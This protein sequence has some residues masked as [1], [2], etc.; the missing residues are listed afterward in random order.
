[1]PLEV[2]V[3]SP[4]LGSSRELPGGLFPVLSP[5]SAKA[6]FLSSVRCCR[7]CILLTESLT[8]EDIV[9]AGRQHKGRPWRLGLIFIISIPNRVA[10]Y[11]LC[12]VKSTFFL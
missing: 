4:N 8:P 3:G 5:L 2:E 1:M 6:P 10:H 9:E 7:C 12:S 11:Q